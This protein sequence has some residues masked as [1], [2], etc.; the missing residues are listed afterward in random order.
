MKHAAPVL[1]LVLVLTLTP[2]RAHSQARDIPSAAP[3]HPEGS[4]SEQRGRALLKQMVEALGGDAWLNRKDMSVHGHSA[5][6]F[7][8]APTGMNVEYSGARQFP[9]RRPPRG[10][11]H[12]LHH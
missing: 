10:R 8:G 11:A 9:R 2:L 1:S 7:H 3:T 12:R 5:A 4:T 6:F